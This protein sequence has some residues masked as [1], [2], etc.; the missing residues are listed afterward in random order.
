M[1]ET[2]HAPPNAVPAPPVDTGEPEAEPEAILRSEGFVD[3]QDMK[4]HLT[5]PALNVIEKTPGK[6]EPEPPT[7]DRV[8]KELGYQTP[9]TMSAAFEATPTAAPAIV[10]SICP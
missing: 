8:E 9:S 3:W 4:T 2:A 6:D 5:D 1:S 10:I 7:H